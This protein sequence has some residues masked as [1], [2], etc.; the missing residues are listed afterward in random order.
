MEKI[1][2]DDLKNYMAR[3]F[4]GTSWYSAIDSVNVKVDVRRRKFSV[5]AQTQLYP[6]PD[7]ETPARHIS[8]ALQGWVVHISGEHNL[9]VTRVGVRGTRAGRAVELRTWDNIFGWRDRQVPIA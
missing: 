9:K 2:L 5:M 1:L 6:G 7:A 4:A 8:M 3:N